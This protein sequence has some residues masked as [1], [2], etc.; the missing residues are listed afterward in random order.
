MQKI[1]Q[2]KLINY[3]AQLEGELKKANDEVA[4]MGEEVDKVKEATKDD[5][6]MTGDEVNAVDTTVNRS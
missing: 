1:K 2:L 3:V 6:P 5:Q 4:A